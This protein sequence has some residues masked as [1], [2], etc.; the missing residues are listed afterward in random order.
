MPK[1]DKTGWEQPKLEMQKSYPDESWRKKIFHFDQFVY[2]R[3]DVF[4]NAAF[5][6]FFSDHVFY[7]PLFFRNKKDKK[8]KRTQWQGDAKDQSCNH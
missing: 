2:I 7:C 3:K 5:S 8:A 4:T 1:K 6:L